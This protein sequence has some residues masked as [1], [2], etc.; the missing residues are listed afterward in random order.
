MQTSIKKTD[1]IN[2]CINPRYKTFDHSF[3][4]LKQL[5]VAIYFF[6][7]RGNSI[8]RKAYFVGPSER[9]K[10]RL[11]QVL[12]RDARPDLNSR[13]AVQI[14]SPLPLRYVPWG[15]TCRY[16]YI[17]KTQHQYKLINK[18]PKTL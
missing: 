15:Y 3:S 7:I 5:L 6:W 2:A 17:S 13:P 1:L 11:S 10:L 4:M 12:T 14:S 8:P 16:M 18:Q 9:V